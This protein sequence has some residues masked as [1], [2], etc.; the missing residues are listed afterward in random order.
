MAQL[1]IGFFSQEVSPK[2]T[3]NRDPCLTESGL[4]SPGMMSE[5]IVPFLEL[6][7]IRKTPPGKLTSKTDFLRLLYGS[8]DGNFSGF[9]G[10]IR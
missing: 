3:K 9:R 5:V 10:E 7:G 4:S 8:V 6:P 1:K 2:I